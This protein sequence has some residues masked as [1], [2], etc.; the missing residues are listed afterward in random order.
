MGYCNIYT[1]KSQPH[2]ITIRQF[3]KTKHKN[4]LNIAF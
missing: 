2:K 1:E 3:K 4:S